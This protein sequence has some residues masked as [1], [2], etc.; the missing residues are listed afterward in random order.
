[1]MAFSRADRVSGLIQKVLAEVLRKQINDPR[2]AM[3][4]VT[5]VKVSPDIKFARV[6]FTVG[7]PDP[8]RIT[9]AKRGFDQ[10]RGFIKRLLA[11]ELGLRYM[12]DLRFHYDESFDRSARIEAL[13][14]SIE[15]DDGR[16]HSAPEEE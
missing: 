7:S 15:D 9:E 4:T 16:D 11:P 14:K 1:M 3:I 13:L 5:G 8:Q 2:L 12:P 10:A 6:Y